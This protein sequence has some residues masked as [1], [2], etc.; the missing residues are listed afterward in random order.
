MDHFTPNPNDL[1]LPLD[2]FRVVIRESVREVTLEC[3]IHHLAV[4]LNEFA[5]IS[6]RVSSPDFI[7]SSTILPIAGWNKILSI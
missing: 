6:N 1:I 3:I 2:I 5:Q 4:R 7:P